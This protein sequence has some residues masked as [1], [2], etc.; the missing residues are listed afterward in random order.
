LDNNDKYA[1]LSP[2]QADC[3]IP[4][5]PVLEFDTEGKMIQGWGGPGQ[6]YEWPDNE[7]GMFVDYK[8]NVWFGCNGQKDTD[9][10]KFSKAGM[11]LLQIGHPWKNR[12]Q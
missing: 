2:P 8:D 5:P 3:C 10:L 6:G 1:A 12:R 7:R 4:A 9:I 11:F